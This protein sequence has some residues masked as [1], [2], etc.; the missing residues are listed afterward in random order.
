MKKIIALVIMLTLVLSCAAFADTLKMGTNANFPPY[1]FYDDETGEIVGIDAE[2]ADAICKQLGYDGV[3]IVDMEFSAIINAVVSGKVDFG[4][5]GMTVTEERLQS[6]DFTTSY[7]T[8]IQSVIVKEGSDITTVDDLFADGANHKVGVQLGTTGDIYCS[9]EI[10]DAGL[11]T[12]ERYNNGTDAV[13]ALVSGKIDCV[14]IDNQPA[15][16]FI[17][18]NEGLKILDTYYAEEDYAICL[19]KDSALTA[20]INE[21]LEALIADGTVQS[22][23]DKYITAE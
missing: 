17:E 10:E 21:A 8:G 9:D 2:V 20:Q 14:V 18:A 11:G 12:I 16:K 3:E 5:A 15:L 22:I 13:V 23:V 6:V 19:A 1:E 4:M 7:A